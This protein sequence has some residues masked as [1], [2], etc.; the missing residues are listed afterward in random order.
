MFS[1]ISFLLKMYIGLLKRKDWWMTS[2]QLYVREKREKCREKN[3][4]M[5]VSISCLN[6]EYL[7]IGSV[8]VKLSFFEFKF[9]YFLEKNN[10]SSGFELNCFLNQLSTSNSNLNN[11]I[12][13]FIL[14]TRTL[15]FKK[16][17]F[18]I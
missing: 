5:E 16:W 17:L 11:F 12:K 3:S 9:S 7:S 13:H 6:D 1:S 15:L 8:F 14:Q 4:A 18:Q 2:I 10:Y